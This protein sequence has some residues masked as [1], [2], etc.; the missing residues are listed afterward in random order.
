MYNYNGIKPQKLYSSI[1]SE[2]GL[3]IIDVGFSDD[4][5]SGCGNHDPDLICT[6]ICPTYSC[7]HDGTCGPGQMDIM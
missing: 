3:S 5:L 2:D 6:P 4:I 7:R 1:N